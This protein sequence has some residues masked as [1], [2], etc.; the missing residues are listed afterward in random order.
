[1]DN[2]QYMYDECSKFFGKTDEFTISGPEL[3]HIIPY[4]QQTEM[5]K[6]CIFEILDG[7]TFITTWSD[8]NPRPKVASINKTLNDILIDSDKMDGNTVKTYTRFNEVKTVELNPSMRFNKFVKIYTIRFTHGFFNYAFHNM[9]PGV[10][11][12]PPK[13][14]ERD[15][16][17]Y[18]RLLVDVEM[19]VETDPLILPDGMLA[20]SMN[21]DEIDARRKIIK[22]RLM[23]DIELKIDR[24]MGMNKDEWYDSNLHDVDRYGKIFIRVSEDSIQ[25]VDELS[26]V[27]FEIQ[28]PNPKDAYFVIS[29]K[30]VKDEVHTEQ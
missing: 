13:V 23:Q 21:I 15:F 17:I 1:M 11:M 5:F 26:R 29:N 4:L 24:I 27:K 18:R 19:D 10:H 3:T 30:N 12:L 7:P 8:E 6:D 14:A 25:P 28:N 22:D 2:I 20:N 9:Q 16:K